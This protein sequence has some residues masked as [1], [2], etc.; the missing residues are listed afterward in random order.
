MDL[1]DLILNILYNCFDSIVTT[2][3]I[4]LCINMI[5]HLFKSYG[6]KKVSMIYIGIIF[7]CILL[8]SIPNFQNNFY[9]L[10][11]ILALISIPLLMKY[12][13]RLKYQQSIITIVTTLVFFTFVELESFAL[14]RHLNINLDYLYSNYLY[15][16]ILTFITS[17]SQFALLVI[18]KCLVRKHYKTYH[19][20]VYNVN[21]IMPQ[22][23]SIA[24]CLVPLILLVS[25]AHFTPPI[26]VIAIAAIQLCVITCVGLY[27][28]Q[29]CIKN[30]QNLQ[31]LEEVLTYNLSLTQTNDDIRG[32]KHDMSNIIQSIVGY[33]NCKDTIGL[34]DY[35]NKLLIADRNI[36]TMACFPPEKINDPAIYGVICSKL[37]EAKEKKLELEVDIND[38]FK[39]INF[40]KHDLARSLGILLD[41]AVYA[42]SSAEN[43]KL[44]L[45]IYY[46]DNRKQDKIIIA[47]SVS[48]FNF[49]IDKIF[50]KDY[51]TKSVPSGFGLYEIKKILKSNPQA[52]I[53]PITDMQ[54]MLFSQTLIIDRENN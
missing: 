32:Y 15:K 48:N 1:C 53:F 28:I 2:T 33:V 24:I 6:N 30:A 44:I 16:Y 37:C 7:G 47:N 35:C 4:F 41:N 42:A 34:T 21:G 14:A 46:D 5:L 17:I 31:K 36:N 22:L 39:L 29:S 18:T 3:I 43:G 38:D 25:I 19:L 9:I 45:S 11:I 20:D 12:V 50:D 52:E 51:S 8:K 13:F 49:D 10:K 23:L 40:S 54:N 27:N 26:T